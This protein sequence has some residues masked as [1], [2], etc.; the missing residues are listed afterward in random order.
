MNKDE[1]GVEALKAAPPVSISGM[2]VAGVSVADWL[3]IATLIYT[4]LQIGLVIMK[5][6]KIL[7]E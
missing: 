5:Y 2:A 1:L 3:L 7:R 4:A 6:L